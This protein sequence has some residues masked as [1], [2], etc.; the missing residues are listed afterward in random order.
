MPLVITGVSFLVIKSR[1]S[2]KGDCLK[3]ENSLAVVVYRTY[4]LCVYNLAIIKGLAGSSRRV[5]DYANINRIP[6]LYDT[7]SE[8]LN[9]LDFVQIRLVRNVSV[10]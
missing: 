1:P 4:S 7:L 5:T 2:I 3:A 10:L 6:K 9:N 8:V